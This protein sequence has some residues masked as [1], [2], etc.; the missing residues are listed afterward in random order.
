[1]IYV[2]H[3]RRRRRAPLLQQQ[4]NNGGASTGAASS[5]ASPPA[6]WFRRKQLPARLRRMMRSGEGWRRVVLCGQEDGQRRT[7]PPLLLRW[8]IEET[9]AR[10]DAR[11]PHSAR[12]G[13][14]R[15]VLVSTQRDHE[16]SSPAAAGMSAAQQHVRFAQ[17]VPPAAAPAA[18]AVHGPPKDAGATKNG[19]YVLRA[20]LNRQGVVFEQLRPAR[21]LARLLNAA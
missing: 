12:R 13:E 14:A 4:Q 6:P 8:I 15:P 17:E 18:P 5:T 11:A 16:A 21:C 3:Q 9:R 7:D 1:M 10:L 2:V 19:R 20:E